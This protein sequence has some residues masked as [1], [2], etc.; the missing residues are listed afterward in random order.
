MVDS[1][2]C[3]QRRRAALAIGVSRPDRPPPERVEDPHELV[4]EKRPAGERIACLGRVRRR[5]PDRLEARSRTSLQP[6]AGLLAGTL[7]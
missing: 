2:R 6:S 7:L 4:R 5:P 3:R 1:V